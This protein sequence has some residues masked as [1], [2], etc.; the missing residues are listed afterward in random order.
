MNKPYINKSNDGF[1]YPE[2]IEV[3]LIMKKLKF[4][5]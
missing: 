1:E 4:I 3:N 5:K 2:K